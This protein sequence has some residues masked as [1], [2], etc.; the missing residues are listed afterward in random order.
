[1]N[2]EALKRGTGA[3]DRSAIPDASLSW[4]L[5]G[6]HRSAFKRAFT[7]KSPCGHCCATAANALA[8]TL[9]KSDTAVSLSSNLFAV[10][11]PTHHHLPPLAP[12]RAPADKILP[13]PA[14]MR[15]LLAAHRLCAELPAASCCSCLP[16]PSLPGQS[17][18]S[19]QQSLFHGAAAHLPQVVRFISDDHC[20][21]ASF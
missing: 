19:V 16:L 9:N 3:R 20:C 7:I 21:S 4:R 8:N 10:H 17:H 2:T 18:S 14:L 1:M 6:A 15:S 12:T 13:V 11:S 5:V